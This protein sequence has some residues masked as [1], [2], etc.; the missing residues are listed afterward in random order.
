MKVIKSKIKNFPWLYWIYLF[1][2]LTAWFAY[3]K[4]NDLFYILDE[5]IAIIITMVF[6]SF[7]AGSSPE[8]SASI[9]YPIFTL[10]LDIMPDVARNFAFAIQS[11]GMTS[12]SIFILNKKIKVDWNYIIYVTIGGL[13]G[14]VLGTYFFI[15]LVKPMVAKLIFVSLWLSFGIILYFEHRDQSRIIK[16]YIINIRQRDILYLLILGLVGGCI[17]SLFGTGINIFTFCFMV[18]YYN[19]NEKVATPSSIIIMTIETIF[20]FFLHA[21][22]IRDMTP[23]TYNMWLSCIPIVVFFAPLGTFIMN[24]LSNKHFSHFLYF[25]FIIQYVGAMFVIRPG[26]GYSLLSVG[27][28]ICGI[29]F[30]RIIS[31]NKKVII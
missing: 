14:L 20:G 22:V 25:I 19:V 3:M 31:K 18:I 8:G 11:I 4:A 2:V 29:V 5:N 12:A 6:G 28:I 15:P 17:S 30:F 10:Y 13:F 9:A 1:I 27:I 21:V 23:A 16:D 7:I 26:L 24:K